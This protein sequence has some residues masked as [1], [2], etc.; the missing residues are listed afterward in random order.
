MLE[1]LGIVIYH[2]VIVS[3]IVVFRGIIIDG[4]VIICICIVIHS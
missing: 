4:T 3:G 1:K 2:G